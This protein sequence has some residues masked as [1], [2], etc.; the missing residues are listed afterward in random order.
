[1][2]SVVI[3]S[4]VRT[5]IGTYGGSLK[6]VPASELG[7]T[8]I[9]AAIER[10]GIDKKDIDDVIFG[11][12][13]QIGEDAYIARV[14]AVKAGLPVDVPAVTINRLCGSGLQAIA[15]A[16]LAIKAGD[17][18]IIVAGGTESMSRVPYLVRSARW[19]YRMGHG[20][21]EDGLITMLND[22][23]YNYH[24]GVTAENIAERFHIT[25]EEQDQFALQSH[26][27]AARAIAEGKFKEQIIPIEIPQRKGE[28]KIVDTDEHVRPDTTIESLAKLKPVFKKDGTVTAGNA[29][30]I[31]DGAAAV[32]VMSESKANELKLKPQLRIVAAA[33]AGVPPEIMGTGPVPAVKKALAKA[34]MKL[35]DID[36]IESNEAFAAQALYVQK[37][38]GFNEEIVNVNGGAIA[39]GHPVGATGCILVVKLMYEMKYRG[40]RYG[41]VTMCCGGGQGVAM[42]FE[43]LV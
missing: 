35:E 26:K 15:S 41:L 27:K 33:A 29:S 21:F 9:K 3:V 13:G 14:C 22:P 40:A 38:L 6:D 2:E 10:A 5:A 32:V 31:N 11:C 36:L 39:L 18:Q 1:M 42:I 34:G 7:A 17:A 24:M 25:R 20:V 19:G 4:G 28:P 43:N 37:E 30:G 16:S 23:F 8:V 12:V